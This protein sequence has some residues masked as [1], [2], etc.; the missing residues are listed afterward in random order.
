MII[1]L[2]VQIAVCCERGEGAPFVVMGAQESEVGLYR[3]PPNPLPPQMII[4]VPVQT[5]ECPSRTVGALFVEMGV[6]VFAAVLYRA[7]LARGASPQRI[8]SVPVQ[9]AQ[10][11]WLSTGRLAGAK[12][13]VRSCQLRSKGPPSL[14]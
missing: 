7:P 12:G 13:G 1:S 5:A 11:P 4:S 9:T 2:P 14:T 3:A 6:Q 10:P 8:I